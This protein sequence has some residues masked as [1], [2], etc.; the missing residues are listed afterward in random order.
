MAPALQ[1]IPRAPGRLPLLGH[2]LSLSRDP[3]GFVKSLRRTG[4]LVRVDLGTLPVVFATSARLAHAVMVTHGTSFEKGRLFDRMR[5][6]VGDG[7]ATAPSAV[8]RPHRRLMQP[9]FHHRRIAGYCETISEQAQQLVDGWEDGRRIAVEEV[10]GEFSV[11]TLAATMFSAEF[12]G[13]AV[14]A[15]R[16]D[17]PIILKTMLLRAVSPKF[18]DRLPIPPNRRFDAAAARLRQVIDEV[19]TATRGSGADHDEQPDLLSTLLAARDA[20][21]GAA[22][23]DAE[24]RDELVTILFAG[25]ETVGSTLSWAFHEIARSPATEA[26]LLA[27]IDAV[28][29]RRPVGHEDVPR[30]T[31]T[32]QVLDEVVRLHGVTLLMR[33]AVA[34]VRLNGVTIP[35]GTEVAFSLYA[36]HQDPALYPDPERFDPDRWLPERRAG[37]PREAFIPFGAGSRQCIG[38]AFAKAEMTI[39]LATVLSRWRLRPVA[40]HATGEAMAAMPHPDH[41]PMVLEARAA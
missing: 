41:L 9:S 33:R 14:T 17:V 13:P 2:V 34:P 15:V 24:V 4:E 37:Q 32:R 8:H 22:L 30:L 5:P 10:M 23:S 36:V 39:T 11:A 20:D 3:L 21:T 6:M 40:G 31:F 19:V 35:A 18:L 28:V 7:L 29:G 16:R 38:D 1:S 12:G 25:T 26:R 27:E